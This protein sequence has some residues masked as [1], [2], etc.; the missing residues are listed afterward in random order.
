MPLNELMVGGSLSGE[1][2]KRKERVVIS[3]TEEVPEAKFTL[4]SS[5]DSGAVITLVVP[6][7]IAFRS[8]RPHWSQRLKSFIPN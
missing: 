6:G 1:S 7:P 2:P 8:A 3:K 4:M 5:R